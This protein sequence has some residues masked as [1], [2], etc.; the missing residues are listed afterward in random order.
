M[1]GRGHGDHLAATS[2]SLACPS[3]QALSA[4][5]FCQCPHQISRTNGRQAQLPRTVPR[6]LAVVDL[7]AMGTF[8]VTMHLHYRQRELAGARHHNAT[9][10]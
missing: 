2:D 5:S 7:L 10:P 6:P 1:G 4:R 3:R 8:F 9:Y